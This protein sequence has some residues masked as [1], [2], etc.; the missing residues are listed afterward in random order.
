MMYILVII[1]CSL[2][3]LQE[4]RVKNLKKIISNFQIIVAS[5]VHD[6]KSPVSAQINILN[7][8]LKGQFGVLNQQQ[9]EIL[10]LACNSNRYISGLVSSILS[11]Y[12]CD[13]ANF[14]PN[15][16]TFNLMELINF[17]AYS[18]KYLAALKNQNI[19][20]N[21]KK[22]S[23]FIKADKLKIERVLSNLISNALIYGAQNSDIIIDVVQEG[24]RINFSVTNKGTYI[25]PSQIKN[26]F[27][28]FYTAGNS[29]VNKNS[30]GFGLYVVKKIIKMHN[31]KIYAKSSPDGICTFGFTLCA[32]NQN[33]ILSS[34]I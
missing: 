21:N 20:I 14:K 2:L 17:V 29:T 26:I 34:K 32:A 22:E 8:L 28:K 24:Y 12:E 30:S 19:V 6:I 13:G 23:Y 10:N 1:F 3:I 15:K 27:N 31:G 4:L 33:K 11:D 16:T 18:N 5:V 7:L 25:E 9:S